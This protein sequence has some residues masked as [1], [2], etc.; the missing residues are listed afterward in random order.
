[1]TAKLQLESSIPT[2]QAE[3]DC[4]LVAAKN[5]EEKSKMAKVDAAYLADKLREGFKKKRPQTW[6]FGS[7]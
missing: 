2:L 7:T 3:V 1:M 4:M 5:A 6:P